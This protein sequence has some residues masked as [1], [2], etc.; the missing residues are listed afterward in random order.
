MAASA[1]TLERRGLYIL[2]TR[3]GWLS[4]A[5]WVAMLA[6]AI[7]YHNNL[8]FLLTFLLG[9]VVLVSMFH[10]HRNLLGL[11]IRTGRVEPV[12]AG[13]TARVEVWLRNPGPRPRLGVCVC[14]D[15]R[16]VAR[17][18]VPAGGETSVQVPVPAR[19]RGRL[20]AISVTLATDHPLGL[21]FSW[22]RPLTLAPR[23]LVYPAPRAHLPLPAPEP[24]RRRFQSE[25]HQAEG[26]DF[27]G[28]RAYREGD[29][30]RHIHWKAVAR[31]LPP[32]TK[33]FGGAGRDRLWL[34]WERLAGLDMEARLS[35]LAQWVVEADRLGLCYGLRLPGVTL[36][37]ERGPGQA[38]ACLERLALF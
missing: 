23:G 5:A 27:L 34:D 32:L 31:G 30:P 11:E 9:A 35:Q 16:E 14:L 19:R 1:H 24:D 18:G 2:P 21:L 37:P 10:T 26:D 3:G 36:D 13:Q 4:G 12:F 8:A 7:N 38:R 6:A 33:E 28:L 20:P 22:S 29:P 25:G 15:R 17:T